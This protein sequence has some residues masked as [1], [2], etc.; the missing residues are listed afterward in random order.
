MLKAESGRAE[1][2]AATSFGERLRALRAKAGM[3]R[4]Q[5][6]A[7]SRTSQR[8]LAHL[9]AGTGNPS[10]EVLQALATAL[11]LTVA[12]LLPMAGERS[13]AYAAAAAAVRRLP[14][15]RLAALQAWVRT[16]SGRSEK[17]RR[18][19]LLG[20]RG[21]GK[22]ALGKD[23]ANRLG[24]P[25]LEMSELVERTYGGPIGLLI[26]LGGQ[27]ALRRYEAEAWES[28]LISHEGAVIAAPGGIVADGPLYE[29]I[30]ITAHSIWLRASPKDHMARVMAQGDFRPMANNREAMADLKAILEARSADYAR[31]DAAVDTSRQD[32]QSTL[33]LLERTSASLLETGI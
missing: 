25:F 3:T 13:P 33:E 8:Y 32:F 1:E 18:I 22:S 21:A 28:L 17:K 31:A 27:G 14:P 5:L 2:A 16:S 29:R 11:D 23:L 26:E 6:A 15:E 19:V 12:E 7:A 10:L 20:L 9:E 30:L 24:L 4:K